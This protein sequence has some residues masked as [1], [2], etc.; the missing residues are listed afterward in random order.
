[1]AIHR[2]AAVLVLLGLIF[3]CRAPSWAGDLFDGKHAQLQY[4]YTGRDN[5]NGYTNVLVDSGVEAWDWQRGNW[6]L[7]DTNITITFSRWTSFG[8]PYVGWAVYDYNNEIA[9]INEVRV[10]PITNLSGFGQSRVSWNSNK[11]FIELSWLTGNVGDI[12]SLDAVAAVPEPSTFILL[13]LGAVSFAAYAWRRK[14]QA[15]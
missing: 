11:V 4:T 8:G 12:V 2:H 1:M 5:V 15:A 10:N 3:A 14:R 6:D 7:S 9:P 13:G